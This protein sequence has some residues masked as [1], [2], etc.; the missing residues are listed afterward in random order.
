MF[1]VSFCCFFPR[2]S[3]THA[4]I[5]I[6]SIYI[7]IYKTR[8]FLRQMV[9]SKFSSFCPEVRVPG[10]LGMLFEVVSGHFLPSAIVCVSLLPLRKL[11][12][13]SEE[14]ALVVAS[15]GGTKKEMGKM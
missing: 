7:H 13:A 11:I 4:Y 14:G 9:P 15:A 3:F 8:R 5:Y 1:V 10:S 12:I 6:Y 2:F